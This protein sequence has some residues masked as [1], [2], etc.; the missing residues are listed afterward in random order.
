MFDG[1]SALKYNV[2]YSGFHVNDKCFDIVW[3]LDQ[4]T[5]I[6]RKLKSYGCQYIKGRDEYTL[7]K[8]VL[9]SGRLC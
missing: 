1:T 8:E 4:H 9:V 3:T 5:E 6:V 7:L 2:D